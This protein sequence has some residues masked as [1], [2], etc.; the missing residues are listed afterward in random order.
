MGRSALGVPL[1]L[2]VGLTTALFLRDQF[3]AIRVSIDGLRPPPAPVSVVI[4]YDVRLDRLILLEPGVGRDACPVARLILPPD[5]SIDTQQGHVILGDDRLTATRCLLA[6]ILGEPSGVRLAGR[7]QPSSSGTESPTL[8]P[9]PAA[10]SGGIGHEPGEMPL[11]LMVQYRRSDDR[12]V[13]G[14]APTGGPGEEPLL[15]AA[16]AGAH[17]HDEDGSLTLDGKPWTATRCVISAA[18]G[19]PFRILPAAEHARADRAG[20]GQWRRP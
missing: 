12:F 7:S 9:D 15:L 20:Q 6:S 13:V 1:A 10:G 16:P 19:G 11:L 14:V 18:R 5:A 4:G 17:F 8:T 2:V 3:G